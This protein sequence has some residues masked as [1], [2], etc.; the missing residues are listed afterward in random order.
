MDVTLALQNT[1]MRSLM[2]N[3]PSLNNISKIPNPMSLRNLKNF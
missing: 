3:S 2:L 1:A